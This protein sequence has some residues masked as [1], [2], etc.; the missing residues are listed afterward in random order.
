MC[1]HAP[2][3][4]FQTRIRAVRLGSFCR[5]S[6]V[7]QVSEPMQKV[8]QHLRDFLTN[9]LSS[10]DNAC[11]GQVGAA[12]PHRG[13]PAGAAAADRAADVASHRHKHH[14]NRYPVPDWVPVPSAA[15]VHQQVYLHPYPKESMLWNHV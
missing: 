2:F 7:L 12:G 15:W 14:L 1:C 9:H 8:I 6:A 3:G 11:L 5:L 13:L 4:G 10:E